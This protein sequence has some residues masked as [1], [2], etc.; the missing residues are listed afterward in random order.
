MLYDL[1]NPTPTRRRIRV[2]SDTRLASTLEK[3]SE[4]QVGV[5]GCP[6]APNCSSQCKK[7]KRTIMPSNPAATGTPRRLE[8]SATVPRPGVIP[9][10][11]HSCPGGS[12]LLQKLRKKQQPPLP[13]A[14]SSSH[15]PL[16]LLCRSGT[17]LPISTTCPLLYSGITLNT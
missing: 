6:Y 12:Q 1:A 15:K 14:G 11:S 17:C 16:V 10:S 2:I 7:S 13:T 8:A 4:G 9:P 3:S 5:W